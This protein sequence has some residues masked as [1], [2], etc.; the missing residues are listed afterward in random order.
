MN[1]IHFDPDRAQQE[2]E[3]I[4]EQA[5]ADARR[6]GAD[7]AEVAASQDRA[8]DATVRL[9]EVETL[10]HHRDRGVTV[11]VYFGKRKGTAASGDLQE[12]SLVDVVERACAIAKHTQEDPCAGLADP[13]RMADPANLPELDLWHPWELSP[14]EAIELALEC[15]SAARADERVTNSEGAS[16]HT[17]AGL[18]CYGNSHGFRGVQRG[19]RHD[20]SCAVIAGENDAMQR[21]YWYSVARRADDLEP[22][23]SVGRRAAERAVRRLNSRRVK[24]ATVPV[25]FVPEVARSLIGHFVAAV[26]G[27]ALYRDASFLVGKKGEKIFADH[28]C[29]SEHPHLPR[30]LGSA[31]FDGE[32]VLTRARKL[33]NDGVLEGYVLNSYSARKLGM[34]TTGNAGGVHNLTV[35]PGKAGFGE[36]VSRMGRGLVVTEMMGQGVNIVTGDY[37]R[38]AAGFWVEDGTMAC[39]VHEITVAGNLADVFMGIEA[40]GNDVDKRANIRTGSILVN[41]MMVAG[42]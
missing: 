10:E 13:E 5:L 25:L 22:A 30:A 38:G 6:R 27:S 37:S 15:E 4:V 8:L 36:L 41:R 29:I 9:G 39:P 35:E 32:G 12:R 19:T 3:A 33:V 24:T 11:T 21:D 7:Q 17:G 18:V 26:R 1:D 16:V 23:Q 42:E 14:D 31:A 28:V 40:V 34:E 20:I 2:L